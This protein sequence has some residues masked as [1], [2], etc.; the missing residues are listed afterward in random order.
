MDKKQWTNLRNCLLE[1]HKTLMNYQ[2]SVYEAQHGKIE[3]PGMFLGL[4]MEDKNF[5]WLRQLSE[6]V[7]V[8]DEMLEGGDVISP[9]KIQDT[10]VYIK[11]LLKPNLEGNEFEQNYYYAINKDPY[12]ALAHGKTLEVLDLI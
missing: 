1:L 2:R 12:S 10:L 3:S 9:D 6:L 7:V 8:I 5:A 4:L 11:R